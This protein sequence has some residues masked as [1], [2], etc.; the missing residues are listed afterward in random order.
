MIILGHLVQAQLQHNYRAMTFLGLLAKCLR[1]GPDGK[2]VETLEDLWSLKPLLY[3]ISSL[4][5]QA[6]LH[7]KVSQLAPQ[8]LR[9]QTRHP[10]L[11][12]Y[13]T[14][15]QIC[16]QAPPL[17]LV[18]PPT[19]GD[20]HCRRNGTPGHWK[21]RTAT[22]QNFQPLGKIIELC[23]LLRPSKY[24][25]IDYKTNQSVMFAR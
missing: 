23:R 15:L 5:Y 8:V 21:I 22:E 16:P 25:K 9:T 11:T 17:N 10:Q 7:W 13:L 2:L 18:L 3:R 14:V 12:G 20:T 24:P 4:F 19:Y 6:R 1:T